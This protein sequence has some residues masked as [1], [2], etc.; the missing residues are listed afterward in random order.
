MSFLEATLIELFPVEKEMLI[1]VIEKE[2]W[3]LNYVFGQ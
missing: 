3:L 1:Q 2:S